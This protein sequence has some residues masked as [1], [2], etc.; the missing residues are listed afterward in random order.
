MNNHRLGL[1]FIIFLFVFGYIG[2]LISGEGEKEIPMASPSFPT[3]DECEKETGI[4]CD[5]VMCDDI[6]EGKTFEEVC[7]KGFMEGWQPRLM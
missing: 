3:K 5:F 7:G 6:P 1:Y 4:I 2:L